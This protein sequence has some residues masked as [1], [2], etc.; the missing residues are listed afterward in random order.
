MQIAMLGPLEV[1]ADA[2]VPV[3]VTGA[4]LR[5]LLILLAL[6]ADRVVDTGRLI[7]GLWE[8]EPPAGAANA[9]QALVSRLRRTVP[10]VPIESHPTGYRL[11]VEPAAVDVSRF[12]QLVGTGRALL[13]SDPP[14]AATALADALDLWRGPALADVADAAFARGPAA[15]LDELR[16]SAVEQR[17]DAR[18]ASGEA[19]A[20]VPELHALVRAHPV[21]ERFAGQLIRALRAANRPAEALAAYA[22]LRSTLAETLGTEPAPE[23][24]ALHLELLR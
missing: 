15:R 3:P 4:R 16:L 5:R 22:W 7:D 17:I 23:L 24:A 11:A 10:D 19:A 14:G 6:D 2:G 13:R 9:L 20:L 21:R 1:T 8:D 12:E 18:L